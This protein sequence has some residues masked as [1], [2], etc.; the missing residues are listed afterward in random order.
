MSFDANSMRHT[1]MQRKYVRNS[2][3]QGA[4]LV[5]FRRQWMQ[6]QEDN[7]MAWSCRGAFG[8]KD[9]TPRGKV[10]STSNPTTP[11]LA[12]HTELPF[13]NQRKINTGKR[14]LSLILVWQ[15]KERLAWNRIFLTT[16]ELEWIS[17]PTKAIKRSTSGLPKCF[18]FVGYDAPG[19]SGQKPH[20]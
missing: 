11:P 3:L 16:P 19:P 18:F 8:H 4:L 13:Q 14:S 9:L 20:F 7:G 17:M 6:G 15:R 2:E 10:A 12:S 5:Q 1:F